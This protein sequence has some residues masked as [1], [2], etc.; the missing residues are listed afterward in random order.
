M[1]NDTIVSGSK[2]R[3]LTIWHPSST[4]VKGVV[5][6]GGGGGGSLFATE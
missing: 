3:S 5:Q 2:D 1:I 4:L 6:S